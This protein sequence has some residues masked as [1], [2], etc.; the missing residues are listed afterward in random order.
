MIAGLM[1]TPGP[2]LRAEVPFVRLPAIV[3]PAEVAMG[4][5]LLHKAGIHS[6]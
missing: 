1:V 5:D 4:G 6:L 2:L 3:I